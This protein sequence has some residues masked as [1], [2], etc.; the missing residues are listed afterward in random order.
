MGATF[1]VKS[2]LIEYLFYKI[3]VLCRKVDFLVFDINRI[4]ARQ[5]IFIN[6]VTGFYL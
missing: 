6:P 3:K 5:E 4:N 1:G 2:E